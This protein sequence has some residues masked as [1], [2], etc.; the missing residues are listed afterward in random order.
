[1]V[2]GGNQNNQVNEARYPRSRLL[3]VR[4]MKPLSKSRT[5]AGAAATGAGTAGTGALEIIQDAQDQVAPLVGYADTLKWV[6]LA[7]AIAGIALTV[8]A[9]LDDRKAGYR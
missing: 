1:M 4:R 6:F 7:L 3:G 8:Y 9:R 5:V 2:L